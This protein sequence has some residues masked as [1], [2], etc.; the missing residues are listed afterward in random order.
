MNIEPLYRQFIKHPVVTTDSR[1][2]T[3]DCIFFAL[4]GD[5]FDGNAFA[6]QALQEG[7]AM[8]VIDNAEY[9]TEGCLLVD[10]VLQSLQSL[11]NYHRR[12]FEIPV[13]SITGSNGKTTTKELITAV[14]SSHYEITATQGNL[15]NH[16]G[17]PLTLLGIHSKTE[18]AVIEM[19]AN[20]QGE[21]KELC[22]IAEPTHGIIT[23][24]GKA[25]L[26]GFGGYEGVI[27]AKTELYSWIK[28]SNGTAFINADNPLL[29]EKSNGLNCIFYGTGENNYV[30]AELIP[31][32]DYL[33]LKYYNDS[34]STC[35]HTQLIGS[36]N[37]ENT[38][39]AICIGKTFQVPQ[40]KIIASIEQYTPSNSRS[41]LL[42]TKRNTIILDAYN[43]NPS[44]MQAAIRN[45]VRI[46]A[47]K[48]LMILGD[49]LELGEESTFE[50]TSIV[51]LALS[52]KLT[53]SIFVGSEFCKTKH[54]EMRYFANSQEA[55]DYL[56]H[57]QIS[58]FTILL[59]G[60]RGI[61]MEKILDTL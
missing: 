24:I 26:G 11:A 45:F 60:S 8:A 35:I 61:K 55:H 4:K 51:E 53:N 1:K 32:D 36:Y 38:L 2:I 28:S 9:M 10:N 46:K 16:I 14:L 13:I 19:G 6:N 41:Q 25:H 5:N 33:S 39:A 7:A 29:V 15:N 27:K 59:K 56:E 30:Q 20:H 22:K 49:M 52:H 57:E 18:I 42:K 44:S 58:G 31:D 17:V 12:K 23:N 21:I 3:R 43:A 50:H 40:A 47:D 48:K 37:F 54:P 34:N